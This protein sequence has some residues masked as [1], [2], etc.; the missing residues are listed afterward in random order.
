MTNR[1]SD[2][3]LEGDFTILP[4]PELFSEVPLNIKKWGCFLSRDSV[5]LKNIF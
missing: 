1:L 3:N 5:S 4:E 2:A